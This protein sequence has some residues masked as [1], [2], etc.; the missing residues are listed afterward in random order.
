VQ[1]GCRLGGIDLEAMT[2]NEFS[3]AGTLGLNALFPIVEEPSN[4]IGARFLEKTVDD[5]INYRRIDCRS[6]S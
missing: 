1:A 6:M 3:R 4:S 5:F 2:G